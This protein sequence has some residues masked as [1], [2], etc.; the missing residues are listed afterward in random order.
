MPK[1]PFLHHQN[2]LM[3]HPN[4]NVWEW[5]EDDWQEDYINVPVNGSALISRSDWDCKL[6]RGGLWC[7][8]ELVALYTLALLPFALF[9][10]PLPR[11]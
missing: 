5:C 2:N 8:E 11:R 4:G 10:F 1:L 9:S 7:G 3:L 6:L